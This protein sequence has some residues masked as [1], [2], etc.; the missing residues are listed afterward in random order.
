MIIELI[1]DKTNFD[2]SYRFTCG[3]TVVCT[4]DTP[5][6][7]GRLL[8]TLTFSDNKVQQLYFAP[9]DTQWGSGLRDRMSFKILQTGQKVGHIY[10]DT[11]K[12]GRIFGSI[13]YY[14]IVYFDKEYA[15]YA[16]GLGKN[17]IFLCG[18]QGNELLFIAEKDRTTVNYHDHYTLYLDNDEHFPLAANALLYYDLT[19]YDDLMKISAYSVKKETLVSTQKELIA[20][21]DPDFI[22]RIKARDGLN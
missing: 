13:P 10:G 9:S 17:G 21:Y 3:N 16:V 20:K 2:M 8:T 15:L 4:A 11:Q 7:V 12:T 19:C 14:R 22:P 5:F 6:E 18:Y 1:Q